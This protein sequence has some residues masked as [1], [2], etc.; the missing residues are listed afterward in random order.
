[1]MLDP[2]EKDSSSSQKGEVAVRGAVD[3]VRAEVLEAEVVGDGAAV[4]LPV[5]AGEGAR[6]ERHHRGA[7][8]RELEA[9]DVAREHPE[10]GEEVVPEVDGLGA[11]EVGVAGHRPVAVA[12]GEVEQAGHAGAAEL[13]RPQG[14]RLDDHRDVGRDLIVAGAAG[15]ELAGQGPNLV[16]EQ[17]LD[18]HVDVLVGV[19]EPEPGLADSDA[20]PFQTGVDPL[21]LLL[22]DHADPLEGADVGLG[23]VDVVRRQ[24]PVELERAVEPP[25][26][27]VRVFAKARHHSSV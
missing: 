19:L 5:D 4:D 2:E 24:P 15:V 12:L 8:E 27:W 10:V 26:A 25:E 9:E 22:A 17:A 3:R 13:D 23:L 16:L 20:N 11:L 7:V 1:M 18:R 14:V 6:A 21:P